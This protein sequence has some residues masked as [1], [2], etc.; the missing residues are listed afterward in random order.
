VGLFCRAL[1]PRDRRPHKDQRSGRGKENEDVI[2]ASR[3][4][5]GKPTSGDD[6]RNRFRDRKRVIVL[7]YNVNCA[8][9]ICAAL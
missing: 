4:S 5:A 1:S 3:A 2:D 7:F 8:V 9:V 6:E